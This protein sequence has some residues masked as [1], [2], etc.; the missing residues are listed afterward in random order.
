MFTLNETE[1]HR[2]YHKR[3][4]VET[5]SHMTKAKFG[6]KVRTKTD[7]AM[8]NEALTKV[9]CHNFCVLIRA[10]YTLGITRRSTTHQKRPL[11]PNQ[12]PLDRL[13]SALRRGSR[14]PPG[15]PQL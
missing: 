5:V 1:F 4:N 7:T 14:M 3:S 10:M 6:D 11:P 15:E 2:H 13:H 8:V 12:R 9:L